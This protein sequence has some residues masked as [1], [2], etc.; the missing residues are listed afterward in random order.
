MLI[1]KRDGK[2]KNLTGRMVVEPP[3]FYEQRAAFSRAY[4]WLWHNWKS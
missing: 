1:A 2:E 4:R 3:L